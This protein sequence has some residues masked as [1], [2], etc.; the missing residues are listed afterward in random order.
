[1]KKTIIYDFDGTLADNLQEMIHL[2]KKY[3]GKELSQKDIKSLRSK[4]AQEAFRYLGIS[5]F[6]IPWIIRQ[7]RQDHS[8]SIDKVYPIKGIKEVLYELNKKGYQQGI[9]TSN[10][11]ENVKLFLKYH[12]LEVFNFIRT[13]S[14]FFGKDKVIRRLLKELYLKP[15]DVLY[16]GDEVRDCEAAR[17]INIKM[18]AVTWGFNDEK[19]LQKQNPEYLVRTPNELIKMLEKMN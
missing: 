9:V 11:E 10:S 12:Q 16:I 6:K 17:K 19:I 2:F 5:L 8:I 15:N 14:S 4:R 7:M 3:A 18:I 1:M 13:G